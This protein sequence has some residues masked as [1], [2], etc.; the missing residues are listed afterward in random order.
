MESC[1]SDDHIAGDHIR[2]DTTTCNIDGPQRSTALERS[3]IDYGRAFRIIISKSK[4][5]MALKLDLYSFKY[6]STIKVNRMM[7]LV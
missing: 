7:T 1:Y 2:M 4:I 3:V 6:F 5:L